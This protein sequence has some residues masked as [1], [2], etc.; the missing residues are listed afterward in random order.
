MAK[1]YIWILIALILFTGSTIGTTAFASGQD[2]AA[3]AISSMTGKA[4]GQI[5]KININ[6]ASIESLSKIPGLSP[7]AGEAITAY[8]DAHGAFKS[9][10]D[11]VNIDGIDAA[12]LQKIKP[13]LSL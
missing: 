8:R 4:Q 10:A 13:F 3:S 9:L 1:Q 5:E 12:L 7:K 2:T 6:T 11:L